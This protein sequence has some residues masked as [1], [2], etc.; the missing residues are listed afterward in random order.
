MKNE[1]RNSV[2]N[3]GGRLMY[4]TIRYEVDGQVAWLTL[5]RPE[6][7]N[8]FTEQMNKE[9]TKALKQAGADRDVR[10]VVITGAGRAFCAGKI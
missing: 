3:K 1:N 8:S 9:M 10:C 5:N 2:G 6:Q 4:E 7:L